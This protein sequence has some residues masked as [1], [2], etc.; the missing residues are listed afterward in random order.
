MKTFVVRLHEGTGSDPAGADTPQLRGV[1][2]EVATGLRVTFRSELEL[3]AAL[4]AAIGTGPPG[5]SRDGGDRAPGGCA[6]D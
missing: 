1:V 4:K 2:D 5:P 3:V 6:P